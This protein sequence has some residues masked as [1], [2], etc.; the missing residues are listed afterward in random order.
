MTQIRFKGSKNFIAFFSQPGSRT[1]LA[2]ERM[3]MMTDFFLFY[4]TT[5]KYANHFIPY[6]KRT[7]TRFR[8][9]AG[10]FAVSH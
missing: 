1:P 10:F 6:S 4:R 8:S 3:T 7:S 2:D 5:A 9:Q